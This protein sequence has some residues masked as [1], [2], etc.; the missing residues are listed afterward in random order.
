MLQLRKAKDKQK[1]EDSLHTQ[2]LTSTLPSIIFLS[3]YYIKPNDK[4]SHLKSHQP[5]SCILKKYWLWNK[6]PGTIT[7][8]AL[9]QNRWTRVLKATCRG[10]SWRIPHGLCN[11][12]DGENILGLLSNDVSKTTFLSIVFY[13]FHKH[14]FPF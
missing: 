12:A 3:L 10:S 1:Y 7:S 4:K 2:T 14:D 8:L 6:Y 5:C 13:G 9:I 11:I